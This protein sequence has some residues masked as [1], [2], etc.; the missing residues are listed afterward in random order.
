MRF[1]NIFIPTWLPIIIIIGEHAFYCRLTLVP[2]EK[3]V[4]Q[5]IQCPPALAIRT[6]LCPHLFCCPSS[7]WSLSRSESFLSENTCAVRPWLVNTLQP[8]GDRTSDIDGVVNHR[9]KHGDFASTLHI[10][11]YTNI[12]IGFILSWAG[13][14]PLTMADCQSGWGLSLPEELFP[15]IVISAS[16]PILP[17]LPCFVLTKCF[18]LEKPGFIPV[19][20]LY[21]AANTH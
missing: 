6:R 12:P 13:S 15:L 2:S 4:A 8:H 16:F 9:L 1:I 10:S 11:L 3:E 18:V 19:S 20:P 17:R 21:A 5:A 14:P 7:C